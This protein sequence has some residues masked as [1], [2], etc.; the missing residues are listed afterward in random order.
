M[1]PLEELKDYI[2]Q[3][4]SALSAYIFRLV[5]QKE[6]CEEIFQETWLKVVA[7]LEDYD[8]SKP[9]KPWL[10][11]IARNLCLNHLK[12]EKNNKEKETNYGLTRK[13]EW[14][15]GLNSH[16]EHLVECLDRLS[17]R[18]REVVMLRFFHDMNLEDISRVMQLPLGTV[19]SRL[20]RGLKQL[21]KIWEE[22]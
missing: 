5:R 19:N 6:I 22:K 1:M 9:F 8:A 2:N 4:G 11:T 10:F 12:K 14:L 13:D 18:H 7:H 15:D 3:T 21:R 16:E 17:S 20:H